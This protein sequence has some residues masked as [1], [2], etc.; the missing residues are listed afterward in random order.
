MKNISNKK[1]HINISKI[2]PARPKEDLDMGCVIYYDNIKIFYI[3]KSLQP[4][5]TNYNV[6]ELMR[7]L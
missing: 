2:L 5:N 4:N 3:P 1:F 7:N 6:S